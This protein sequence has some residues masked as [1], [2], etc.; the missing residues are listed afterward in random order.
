MIPVRLLAKRRTPAD[1]TT[2]PV[3]IQPSFSAWGPAYCYTMAYCYTCLLS[4][5]INDD[6]DDRDSAV[7][8]AALGAV[9]VDRQSYAAKGLQPIAFVKKEQSA[10]SVD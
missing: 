9:G 7:A 4:S 2:K 10:I 5:Q 1:D 3:S 6:C 8:A